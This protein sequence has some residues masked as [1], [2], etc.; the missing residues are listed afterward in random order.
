MDCYKIGGIEFAWKSGNYNLKKDLF[1]GRFQENISQG[2]NRVVYEIKYVPLERYQ[3]YRCLQKNSTYELYETGEEMFLIY[4]WGHCRFAYGFGIKEL[5]NPETMICYFNPRINYEIPL[6]ASR[7][8]STAGMHSKLLMRERLVLHA[9]YIEWNGKAVLFIAPSGTGKSTQAMLWNQ[10]EQA[11]II[12]GDRALVGRIGDRW[13]SYGYPCCGSSEI[14][15]NRTL[16]L[17][18]V[19][20]LEQGKK[21]SIQTMTYS[22][23]VKNLVVGTE[24]FL[25]MQ[26]EVERSIN[27]AEKLASKIPIITLVCRPDRG[28]VIVLKKYLE[29]LDN[30]VNL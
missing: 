25:F 2:K 22:Q 19:V 5:K 20:V 23:K 15:I 21:D 1:M 14:C 29:E 26:E 7:L 27:L 12:N 28:A 13:Y 4:H 24:V 6:N 16:P 3:Q 30:A 11:E 18:A 9:A 17:H 8:F 10:Y